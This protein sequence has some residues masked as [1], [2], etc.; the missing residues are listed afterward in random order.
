MKT[1]LLSPSAASLSLP[2][3]RGQ[4]HWETRR[5]KT[6]FNLRDLALLFALSAALLLPQMA[7]A[8][9]LNGGVVGNVTDPA[10]AAVPGASVTLTNITTTLSRETATDAV[11]GYNFATVQPGTY[12]IKVTRQGFAV[13]EHTNIN[14]T[15]DA[16]LRVDVT[17][18]VGAATDSVVVTAD[19]QVLQTESGEVRSELDMK[20]LESLP[21][22]V[23]RN[24]QSLLATVPGMTPPTSAHSVG[25]NPSRALTFFANGGDYLENNSRIDGAAVMNMWLPDIVAL[26]PTLESIETLNV[27]TSNF[28][29]DSGFSGGAN[30]GVHTKSG[31]NSPHGALFESYT[32]NDLKARPFFL[33]S[34]QAK[35]KLVYHEFG[36]AIGY[37]IIKDKLFYFASFEGKRDHEFSNVLQ[38]VPDALTKSG[39]MS[40]SGTA[41]YDP[42][43]GAANG[44]GRTPFPNNQIPVARMDPIA[45]K[46]NAMLPLP[47]VPGATLTNNFN[48][49]GVYIF[50]RQQGDGK[51]N[52]N[53]TSK[54]SAF[55]R[56]SILDYNETD[57]SVFGAIG[58]QDVNTQGGDAG[59]AIGTTYSLTTSA[60]YVLRPTLILDGYFAWENDNTASEPFQVGQNLGQQLGIPGTNGPYR[61]QSGWPQF[62]VSNYSSFGEANS[63]CCGLPY[64][65]DDHQYQEVVNLNWT[66]GGHDLRVG[67]EIQQQH[68]NNLQITAAM[69]QGAFSFGTGP[70]QLSGGPAGNQFNSWATFLLGLDT[71]STGVF[72]NNPPSAPANQHW[73]SGYIRDR[74]NISRKLTASLGLRWDYYGFPNAQFRGAGGYDIASNQA[75]ICGMGA[76]PSNC[77]TSMPKD[78]FSPRV[79]LAF[80]VSSTFVI[81]GGYGIN[82]LPFSLARAVDGNYP[83]TISASYTAPNS[84]SWY[85]TLEQGVPA[86]PLPTIAN[87]Y[88][89]APNNVGMMVFPKRFQWPY[90]E[91]WNVTLQKELKWGFTGQLG[92]V[93]NHTIREMGSF[94]ST[95][96]INADQ[97][98]NTGNAGLPFYQSE[99]RTAAV[100]EF[101]P[102]G[103]PTY[104][105]MQS[106]LNRRFKAGLQLAAAWTWSKTED[107]NYPAPAASLYQYLNSRPVAGFDRTHTLTI[108]GSW[109]LPFGHGKQWLGAS[110]VGNAV[111]GGWTLNSLAAFYSGQPFS[112]TTSSTSLNMVGAT[113]LPLQLKQHVAMYGNIG[114]A[115]FDPLAFAPVTTPSFGF[116]QPEI[117]RGPG[118]VDVDAGLSR[119]WRLKERFTMQFRAEAFNFTNTPHFA[120]PGG[121]VSNLV[122]NGD[123]TVKNLAGFAQVTAVATSGRDGIDE[124]QFRFTMRVTF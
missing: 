119:A 84:Y 113:Q 83:N 6:F 19:A 30:I 35:G 9:S 44:T 57:P 38:T 104:N 73:Y 34:N 48:G 115:Y 112:I 58:G 88:L 51:L 106:S 53:P 23:G 32:G 101:W 110:K 82:W 120:N 16:I 94:G 50:D 13:L 52:W 123:G 92:Y 61:Y 37:K 63:Q 25:T 47:N 68:L 96:N 26:V 91:N 54:L 45:L 105:A 39:N 124:R 2:L 43:T 89:A 24:Y 87:G 67:T 18:K 107:P 29:A 86:T 64:Y 79:G 75:E 7:G 5:R 59:H 65:R 117:L 97:F 78:L 41:I 99:G 12:T 111:L 8:Q 3:L 42:A 62:A 69:A 40:E 71:A 121:N 80:R 93:G 98:I 116:V 49:N 70:T 60:T 22:P 10:G 90:N 103:T 55:A 100:N 66:K 36:A 11:G 81:R 76:V 17:L 122:L 74:W 95:V 14:V 21:V 56:F 46:L 108:N 33:P 15:A 31:T 118:E 28:E 27:A 102:R 77:G 20:A 109:E 85:G 114:G 4:R 1:N 72:F